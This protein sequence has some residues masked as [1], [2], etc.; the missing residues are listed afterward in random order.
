MAVVD[1]AVDKTRT[2]YLSLH[3]RLSSTK[4]QSPW[5]SE[6]I[7]KLKQWWMSLNTY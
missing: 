7:M 4:L 3:V 6:L 5:S 1:D 2:C